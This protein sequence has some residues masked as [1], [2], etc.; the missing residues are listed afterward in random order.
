MYKLEILP[1]AIEDFE[2]IIHYI[3]YNLSNVSAAKKQRDLFLKNLD[4][5]IK[6]PYG[7]DVYKTEKTLTLKYRAYKVKNYLIFYTIDENEKIVTIVRVLYKKMN[8]NNILS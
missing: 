3:S 2:N 8:V 7:C 5:I 6:F 4:N 1:I